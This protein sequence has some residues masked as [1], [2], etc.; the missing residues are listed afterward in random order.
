M[1]VPEK[2]KLIYKSHF[3]S[4]KNMKRINL[5]LLQQLCVCVCVCCFPKLSLIYQLVSIIHLV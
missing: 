3:K 5:I 2:I 1:I 4:L